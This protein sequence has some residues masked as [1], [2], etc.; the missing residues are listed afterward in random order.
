[1]KKGVQEVEALH[2]EAEQSNTSV[3]NGDAAHEARRRW[4]P[5]SC[6]GG[7]QAQARANVTRRAA[8][9]RRPRKGKAP[10][11]RLQQPPWAP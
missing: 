1:M 11:E 9:R 7:E 5:K 2:A 3:L 10:D 8:T 4:S 6:S